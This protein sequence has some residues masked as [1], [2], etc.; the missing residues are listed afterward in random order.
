MLEELPDACP[1]DAYWS[2]GQLVNRR[3]NIFN[4][5]LRLRNQ[6][7][8][9]ICV[10]Y[11]SYK[12]FFTDIG[13]PTA[14]YFWEHYPS[15]KYLRGKTVE[16]LSAELKPISH[17]QLSAKRCQ[18]ILDAVYSD[19]TKEKK[20][21]NSRDVITRGLEKDLQHQKNGSFLVRI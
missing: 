13:R 21:R 7:H 2:L 12:Q 5:I 16:D 18:K 11:P 20:Y 9:Q 10:A 6:L 3:G 14:L 4:H 17:N 19:R 8:E 15:E 1:N